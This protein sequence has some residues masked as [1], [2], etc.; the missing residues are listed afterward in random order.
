MHMTKHVYGVYSTDPG[1]G[2]LVA[3]DQERVQRELD[4]EHPPRP[5]AA[6]HEGE[7]TVVAYSVVHGRDGAP[8]WGIAVCDLPDSDARTYAK[9]TD[10]EML[11]SV[12]ERELVGSRVRLT[13]SKVA[14]ATG[15]EGTANVAV[16]A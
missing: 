5:I 10:A 13:P 3:P 12:E 6:E 11:V 7:A 9:M 16:P 2:T 15:G 14:L 1:G 4:A 8:E